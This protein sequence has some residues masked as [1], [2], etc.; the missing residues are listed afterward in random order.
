LKSPRGTAR[1][2]DQNMLRI[3]LENAADA[4][5]FRLEGKLTGPWVNEFARSWQDFK[6]RTPGTPVTIDLCKVS[7]IDSEG[8]KLLKQMFQQGAELRARLMTKYVVDEVIGQQAGN[9]G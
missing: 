3:T 6:D 1:A 8:K 9:G 4:A 7:F 2:A 5:T